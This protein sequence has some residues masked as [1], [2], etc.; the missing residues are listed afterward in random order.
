ME[1]STLQQYSQSLTLSGQKQFTLDTD[2]DLAQV[3]LA[4]DTQP[5]LL[6]INGD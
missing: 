2:S 4:A 5:F 3:T 6:D 1:D